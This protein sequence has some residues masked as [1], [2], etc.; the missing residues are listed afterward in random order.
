MNTGKMEKSK[1][2]LFLASDICQISEKL[3]PQKQEDISRAIRS[4]SEATLPFKEFSNS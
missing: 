4:A 3:M 1:T 2:K